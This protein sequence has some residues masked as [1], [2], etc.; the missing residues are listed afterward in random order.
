MPNY[1]EPV[2]SQLE[3]DIASVLSAVSGVQTDISTLSTEVATVQTTVSGSTID[4]SS[5]VNSLLDTGDSVI[6]V[7]NVNV[8]SRVQGHKCSTSASETTLFVTN[9]A[10]FAF[11]QA[12]GDASLGSS[13]IVRVY[14]GSIATEN[15]V[16]YAIIPAGTSQVVICSPAYTDSGFVVTAQADGTNSVCVSFSY[17]SPQP[18]STTDFQTGNDTYMYG[19]APTTPHDTATFGYVGGGSSPYKYKSLLKFDLSAIPVG[20]LVSSATL[21]LKVQAVSGGNLTD[22]Q[23]HKCLKDWVEAQA[24]WNE[25][26]TGNNWDM[27]GASA[28]T[29]TDAVIEYNGTITAI[30]GQ[31]VT[32][33]VTNAVK[34]WVDGT[35]SNFGFVLLDAVTSVSTYRTFYSFNAA[36]PTDRPKLSV[37]LV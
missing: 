27:G 24:T 9:T 11:V 4:V 28:V 14:S 18:V 23:I 19:F 31:E 21:T 20:S 37:S 10:G 8:G 15:L 22:F 29:D 33:D 17:Y 26:S 7:P 13:A 30:A 35:S 36:S 3:T 5:I 25:Y 12:Y 6:G 16:A 1:H 2:T 32:F 34:S